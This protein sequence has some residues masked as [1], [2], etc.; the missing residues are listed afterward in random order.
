MKHTT[1]LSN[2]SEAMHG[3]NVVN[4]LFRAGFISMW[5]P[6][7]GRCKKARGYFPKFLFD[8]TQIASGSGKLW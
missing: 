2:N 4:Y 6:A 8:S 5:K 1:Q 7:M 3:L